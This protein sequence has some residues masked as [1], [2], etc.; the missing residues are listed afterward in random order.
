[1]RALTGCDEPW[2]FFH[3]WRHHFWPKLASS[4][5]DFCGRRRSFQWCQHQ[6]DRPNGARDMHKNAQNVERKA[7]NKICCHY[8]WLL[9]GKNRSAMRT[10]VA[11][12]VELLWRGRSQNKRIW[13][14]IKFLLVGPISDYSYRV[15]S[16]VPLR[17][18][19]TCSSKDALI[20]PLTVHLFPSNPTTVACCW[21]VRWLTKVLL[22]GSTLSCFALFDRYSIALHNT[23]C[24]CQCFF[25]QFRL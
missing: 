11:Y 8:T 5:L 21:C 2:P 9:Y 1:M 3:F 6:S 20:S 10:C 7:Q 18:C 17:V 15:F 23:L 12:E 19:S 16:T 22:L 24:S 13:F 4:M 14:L 25:W